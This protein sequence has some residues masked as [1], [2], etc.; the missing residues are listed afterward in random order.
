MSH[1]NRISNWSVGLFII[2]Y[3]LILSLPSVSA[4]ADVNLPVPFIH[5]M[6]DTPDNFNGCWACGATSAVMILAYY[7]KLAPWPFQPTYCGNN[8][9][10]SNYGNYVSNSYSYDN[11]TFDTPTLAPI[12]LDDCNIKNACLEGNITGLP[13]YGAY[14]YISSQDC[15]TAG[16]AVA[17]QAINFFKDHGLTSQ[18][19]PASEDKVK[20][21]LD[22][23]YP[24]YASSQ[25]WKDGHI[26]VIK[27]YTTVGTSNPVSGPACTPSPSSACSAQ[28]VCY[29]VNDPWPC[30]YPANNRT[31][32]NYLYTW[33]QIRGDGTGYIVT[34]EGNPSP[35]PQTISIPPPT[36]QQYFS[37]P[38]VAYP[39]LNID[40][41][42]A[43]PIGVG[44]AAT[45]GNALS[46]QVSFGQFASPVD[47]YLAIY[48]PS[49]NPN[50]FLIS[51]DLSLQ[52]LSTLAK[53]KSNITGPVNESL[54][55][56]IP[57]S[58]FQ[59]G[60]YYLLALV[61]PAGS[62]DSYYL[63]STN[64]VVV[65]G[66]PSQTFN[67]SV[68][69]T[70][71]GSGTVSADSGQ[72]TWAGNSGTASYSN[73]TSVTLTATPDSGSTFSSWSGCDST[74]GNTCTVSMTTAKSVTVMFSTAQTLLVNGNEL[75]PSEEKWVKFIAN[76]VVPQLSGDITEQ[77][78]V[79]SL[80]TW[81]SLKGR[82]P[83]LSLK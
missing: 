82:C 9:P 73:G 47:I 45:G 72:I 16:S 37:Y 40:P 28:H 60:T 58:D 42:Q 12:T 33:S 81:W 4:N 20:A 15:T 69:R 35:P 17:N 77:I 8:T 76:T 55:G 68:S 51:S 7:G 18:E 59:T 63:W 19:I 62:V 65:N 26:I 1:V 50:Y 14:G 29:I 43:K 30:G 11:N 46:L 53:W 5:Q 41:S 3:V 74:S 13:A 83:V 24:V 57:L 71:A 44:S 2:L 78:Q 79:A 70:G 6:C 38:P 80:S 32:E 27:G 36:S 49:V 48:A 25:L 31:G 67:L 22:A 66:A 61:T 54:Y 23:G 52:P 39:V 56:D 64:F 21:E 75:T 10:I 34:A